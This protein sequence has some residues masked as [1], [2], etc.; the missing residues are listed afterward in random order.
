MKILISKGK[1]FFD[2][3]K[4]YMP[5]N[6]KYIRHT[7]QK[8]LPKVKKLKLIDKNFFY[9]QINSFLSNKIYQKFIN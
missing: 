1:E 7:M 5:Y 2:I 9:L 8:K 4:A 3:D 6:V